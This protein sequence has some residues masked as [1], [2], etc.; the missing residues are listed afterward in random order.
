MLARDGFTGLTFDA[1]AAEANVR[2]ALIAYHFGNK[3]GLVTALVDSVAHDANRALANE[4][5]R[6][7]TGTRRVHLLI[8]S[9]R[10]ISGDV[11]AYQLFFDL[12]PH[13]LRNPDLRSRLATLYSWYRDLDAWAIGAGRPGMEGVDLEA[14]S[15]LTVAVT[16]GLALQHASDPDFD[17]LRAYRLWESF[18]ATYLKIAAAPA[19]G[20]GAPEAVGVASDGAEAEVGSPTGRPEQGASAERG[21]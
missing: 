20:T 21:A 7:P 16:E 11:P 18:V 8:D 5:R 13:I 19:R 2:K 6:L 4:V 9:H 14:L 1:I 17:M 3:D 12:V 15:A 10:V